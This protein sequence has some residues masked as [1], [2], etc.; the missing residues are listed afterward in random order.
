MV[1][2][3]SGAVFH[4]MKCQDVTKMLRVDYFFVQYKYIKIFN[5]I[6]N[7]KGELDAQDKDTDLNVSFPPLRHSPLYLKLQMDSV[8]WL[9]LICDEVRLGWLYLTL[10]TFFFCTLIFLLSKKKAQYAHSLSL[11]D[12]R[13]LPYSNCSPRLQTVA[14]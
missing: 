8:L 14:S 3:H 1:T 12:S 2:G 10:F 6:T 4:N 7:A 9:T 11:R 13:A 5:A